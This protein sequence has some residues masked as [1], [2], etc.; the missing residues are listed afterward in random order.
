MDKPNEG[1]FV[2]SDDG[3]YD[4]V[5]GRTYRVG[6]DGRLEAST[7]RSMLSFEWATVPQSCVRR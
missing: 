2:V 7:F 3:V 4:K 5:T 1:E 6:P